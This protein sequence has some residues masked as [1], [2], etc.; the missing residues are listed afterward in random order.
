MSER[1][2]RNSRTSYCCR[3]LFPTMEAASKSLEGNVNEKGVMMVPRCLVAAELKTESVPNQA[4]IG[5]NRIKFDQNPGQKWWCAI[6]ALF[7]P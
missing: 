4:I 3:R 6:T 5:E 1:E 2:G 7:G